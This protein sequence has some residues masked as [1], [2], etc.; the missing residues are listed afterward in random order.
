MQARNDPF[1]ALPSS[2][3]IRFFLKASLRGSDAMEVAAFGFSNVG[4]GKWAEQ[5]RGP[6]L[7]DPGRKKNV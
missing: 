3:W 2:Q 1:D 7:N 6:Q 5:S 4:F